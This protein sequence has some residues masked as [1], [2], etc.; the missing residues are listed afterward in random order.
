MQELDGWHEYVLVGIFINNAQCMRI[1]F[2]C[3][4]YY[5]LVKVVGIIHLQW[6]TNGK[7]CIGVGIG[8]KTNDTGAW[9]KMLMM[10]LHGT[11]NL[12]KKGDKATNQWS[13]RWRANS[14]VLCEIPNKLVMSRV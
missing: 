13:R 7:Y 5:I 9:L 3:I 12:I 4:W 2:A 6:T 14:I 11:I 8:G 1:C 10:S